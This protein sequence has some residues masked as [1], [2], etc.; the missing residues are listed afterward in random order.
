MKFTPVNITAELQV[1]AAFHPREV[2]RQLPVDAAFHPDAGARCADAET[3]GYRHI[4]RL[5]RT[6]EID[7]DAQVPRSQLLH[8]API[9]LLSA[10]AAAKLVDHAG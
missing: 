8:A 3:A 4:G 10:K 1:V 5:R 7:I 9:F 2:V 6:L